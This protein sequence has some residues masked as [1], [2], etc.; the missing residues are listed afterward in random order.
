MP[1]KTNFLARAQNPAAS[2]APKAQTER[3]TVWRHA[4]RRSASRAQREPNVKPHTFD[5]D[6]QAGTKSTSLA[7]AIG[8]TNA[9]QEGIKRDNAQSDY[10]PLVRYGQQASPFHRIPRS[11]R[12]ASHSSRSDISDIYFNMMS[13][14]MGDLGTVIPSPLPHANPPLQRHRRITLHGNLPSYPSYGGQNLDTELS[15]HSHSF[16]YSPIPQTR[17]SV[18]RQRRITL[19]GGSTLPFSSID[20]SLRSQPYHYLPNNADSGH[21]LAPSESPFEFFPSI[22][23]FQSF[24]QIMYSSSE[25]SLPSAPST[26]SFPSVPQTSDVDVYDTAPYP[27]GF[28][29]LHDPLSTTEIPQFCGSTSPNESMSSSSPWGIPA[30]SLGILSSHSSSS[31]GNPSEHATGELLNQTGYSAECDRLSLLGPSR[32][33]HSPGINQM[34]HDISPH[35]ESPFSSISSYST[36][37]HTPYQPLLNSDLSSILQT[38]PTPNYSSQLENALQLEFSTATLDLSSVDMSGTEPLD[39]ELLLMDFYVPHDTEEPFRPNHL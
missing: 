39:P 14:G 13:D 8:Q 38:E 7:P 18:Q 30:G 36:D 24:S 25:T 12:G 6:S 32:H 11:S 35:V 1:K 17:Q 34:R 9:S 2:Q 19:H 15:H 31:L 23:S 20:P 33:V 26:T 28:Y 21:L 27:L 5:W 3:M 10:F 22:P 29:S 4:D 16:D 37:N